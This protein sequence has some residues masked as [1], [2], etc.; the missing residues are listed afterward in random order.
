MRLLFTI[1]SMCFLSIL[2]SQESPLEKAEMYC[3]EGNFQEGLSL[4]KKL[5]NKKSY[6]DKK[7]LIY[8]RIAN[9]Y[10]NTNYRDSAAKYFELCN[11]LSDLKEDEF[12]KY[13]E[14]LIAIDEKE[15]ARTLIKQVGSNLD[16]K[17][18]K[19]IES[20]IDFENEYQK[21]HIMRFEIDSMVKEANYISFGYCVVNSNLY[22]SE[23]K[24]S[25]DKMKFSFDYNIY[26]KE[27]G[28]DDEAEKSLVYENNF[29]AVS[30]WVNSDETEMYIVSNVSAKTSYRN[31]QK[32]KLGLSDSGD[33]L[34]KIVFLDKVDSKWSKLDSI[35]EWEK[36]GFNY[37]NPF[38]DT[39]NN[40]LYFSSDRSGDG[41]FKIY[42]V[43]KQGD[44]WGEP[45]ILGKNINTVLDS[46]FPTIVDGYLYF[47]SN[48]LPGHGGMDIYRVPLNNLESEA[49]NMPKPINSSYD[50]FDVVKLNKNKILFS[51]N[52][53]QKD[54]AETWYVL[55]YEIGTILETKVID[56][57]SDEAISDVDIKVVEINSDGDSLIYYYKSDSLGIKEISIYPE[58]K[59]KLEF[60]YMDST[61]Y[62]SLKSG[63]LD[64]LIVYF[65][66]KEPPEVNFEFDKYNIDKK[67]EYILDEV[68]DELKSYPDSNYIV[69]IEG[70][71][72]RKGS[73]SYNIKLS[74]NRANVVKS[75]LVKNGIPEDNIKTKALYFSLLKLECDDCSED[76]RSKNR[77]SVIKI[78][79]NK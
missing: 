73:K 7:I 3:K 66:I 69:T 32:D 1:L 58:S 33:N 54:A 4:Y 17:Y 5:L 37:T 8:N 44:I 24:T 13:A 36:D 70:H 53:K 40:E 77:R 68:I 43:K 34:V 38:F 2:I 27:F 28:L 25:S 15:K 76:E 31:R 10:Y 52:R 12:I 35:F 56:R 63:D 30:P 29:F 74:Q 48:G 11:C 65:G 55:D 75:Y 39:I 67:Y 18:L 72:D 59:Y 23:P 16:L 14:S 57:R 61:Q 49:E 64:T 20:K 62:F 9:V 26:Q 79:Y 46:Y 41:H 47:C 45:I 6:A 60:T 19:I 22:Y 50:D 51:S 71:T 42:K 78:E 21:K